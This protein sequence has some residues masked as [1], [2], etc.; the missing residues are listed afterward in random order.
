MQE[1]DWSAIPWLGGSYGSQAAA[2]SDLLGLRMWS[3]HKQEPGKPLAW[4]S[5][6]QVHAHD[7][8]CSAAGLLRLS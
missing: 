2:A 1:C 6:E 7:A 5:Q 4:T 3:L 8:Q